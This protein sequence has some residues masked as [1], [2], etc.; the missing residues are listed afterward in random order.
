[1]ISTRRIQPADFETISGFACNAE[2]LFYI[3]PFANYPWRAEQFAETLAER[4]SNTVFSEYGAIVG[5]ANYY[6]VEFGRKGFIGNV[7]VNPLFRRQGFGRRLLQH[8]IELGFTEHRFREIHLSCFSANT[9]GM[10]L[11]RKLGFVPYGIEQ[12]TDYKNRPAALINF[13]LLAEKNRPVGSGL[14]FNQVAA[15]LADI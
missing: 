7:I 4:L 14:E 5:F 9:P 12:R 10:L 3:A 6:D 2:E 1:M 11:Y 15:E 13:K 8:M